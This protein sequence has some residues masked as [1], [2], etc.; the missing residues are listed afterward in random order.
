MNEEVNVFYMNKLSWQ[1]GLGGKREGED[2]REPGRS[3]AHWEGRGGNCM[4]A[5]ATRRLV[6]TAEG[7]CLPEAGMHDQGS[8][9]STWS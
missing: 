4:S 7:S 6:V 3:P 2:L 9:S 1:K 5:A 8:S